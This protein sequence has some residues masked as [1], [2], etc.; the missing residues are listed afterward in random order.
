MCIAASRYS[1]SRV[2]I[3]VYARNTEKKFP[4]FFQKHTALNY[5]VHVQTHVFSDLWGAINKYRYRCAPAKEQHV[6]LSVEKA[7][8]FCAHSQCI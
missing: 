6:F 4:L 8:N 5:M 2:K 1:K 7:R 3:Q